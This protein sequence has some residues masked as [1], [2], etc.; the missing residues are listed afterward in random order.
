MHQNPFSRILFL[1]E[2]SWTIYETHSMKQLLNAWVMLLLSA[3]WNSWIH[4]QGPE[5]GGENRS[6]NS[7]WSSCHWYSICICSLCSGMPH[8]TFTNAKFSTLNPLSMF[9]VVNRMSY[10]NGKGDL[11]GGEGAGLSGS[12][13]GTVLWEL[14]WRPWSGPHHDHHHWWFARQSSCWLEG[15]LCPKQV[16]TSGL[17]S[18]LI[19]DQKALIEWHP[20][21]MLVLF[22]MCP[23]SPAAWRVSLV[24]VLTQVS[25]LFLSQ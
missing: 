19:L 23:S 6:C 16:L 4:V 15:P 10:W 5:I 24:Y 11:G 25:S 20:L 12:T 9:S 14:Q 8:T 3:L 21:C 1:L 17:T 22:V 18:F 13:M 7:A 2:R